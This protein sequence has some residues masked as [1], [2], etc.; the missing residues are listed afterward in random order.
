MRFQDGSRK[1]RRFPRD[2]PLRSVHDW[3]LTHSVEA[4]SGREFILAEAAPGK[5]LFKKNL[6]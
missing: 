6:E 4:A 5:H 3:C 1:Q 2:A